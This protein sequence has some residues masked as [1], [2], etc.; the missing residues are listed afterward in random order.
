MK[1]P[2]LL[3]AAIALPNWLCNGSTATAATHVIRIDAPRQTLR[4]F[5]ASDAWSM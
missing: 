3:T 2:I 5:G 1:H 4:H